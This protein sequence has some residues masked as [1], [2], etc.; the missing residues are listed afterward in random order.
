V[1]QVGDLLPSI[2]E[3]ETIYGTRIEWRKTSIW[4]EDAILE[5]SFEAVETATVMDSPSA[6]RPCNRP[7]IEE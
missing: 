7:F 3:G 6:T 5:L 4:L 2:P 1:E